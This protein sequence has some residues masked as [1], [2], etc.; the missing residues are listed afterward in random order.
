[1]SPPWA[2]ESVI[3]KLRELS[4]YSLSLMFNTKEKNRLSAGK[5]LFLCLVLTMVETL[6]GVWL[7]KVLGDMK[8]KANGSDTHSK[9]FLY[10]AVSPPHSMI[11]INIPDLFDKK[12]L[13]TL[14]EYLEHNMTKIE[15]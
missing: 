8:S 14:V 3:A 1:M 6:L 5:D 2:T 7:G 4:D 9:L 11:N 10:S 12:Q 13:P 15:K